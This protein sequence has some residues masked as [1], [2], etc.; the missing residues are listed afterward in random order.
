MGFSGS[1]NGVPAHRRSIS[2]SIRFSVNKRDLP[3]Y[4]Y[5]LLVIPLVIIS[6]RGNPVVDTS[7][8][9]HSRILM[10]PVSVIVS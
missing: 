3:R 4:Y 5:V 9:E 2:D 6:L 8:A 10:A 7:R 1:F